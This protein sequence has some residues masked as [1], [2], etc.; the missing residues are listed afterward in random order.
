MNDLVI[1]NRV[2]IPVVNRPKVQALSNKL[3]APGS[4]WDNDLWIL[5]DWYR[6]A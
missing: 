1:N 3:H 6:D 5:K 4:G 2:V